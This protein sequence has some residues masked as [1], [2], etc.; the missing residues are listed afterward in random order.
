MFGSRKRIGYIA[1]TVIEVVAY[2]F[3]RFAPDGVGL[4]GV[5][6]S[7]DD[8]RPSEFEKGLAQVAQAAGYLGSRG[9]DFIIH[10][11]GPLVVARGA[12][13]EEI[14]V[15]DIEAASKVKATTAV[16]AGMEAL[17]H[18]GARRIAIAS[19]Y[20]KRHNEALTGYLTTHG[21]EV[22]HDRAMDLPFKEMQNL[23]PTD[24]RAFAAGA[25]A[26]APDCDALYLPCPQWQAAQ[27][28]DALERDTGKLV[29]AYTHACFYVAFRAMGLTD[30]IAGH[31]RLLASL[32]GAT[33]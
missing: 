20:P 10:G 14:I 3:Y 22:V 26:A 15:R 29:V 9:V 16:R 1:P 31:G 30:A 4:T 32:N 21:F 27:V 17:R 5:T 24:I 25:L 28:V 6:C 19:P 7:I 18:V 23:P 12:G 8:W 33:P 11:G 2:E 13:Y